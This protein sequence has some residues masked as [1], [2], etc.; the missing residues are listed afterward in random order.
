MPQWTSTSTIAS[1]AG[2]EYQQAQD[3]M[4]CLYLCIYFSKYFMSSYCAPGVEQPLVGD[5]FFLVSS[6][7]HFK[8][9][10]FHSS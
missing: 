2:P 1:L 4:F 10:S 9:Y 3:G 6:Y 8:L 5:N 7:P